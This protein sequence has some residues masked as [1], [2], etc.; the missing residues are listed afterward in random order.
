LILAVPFGPAILV[1]LFDYP[2]QKLKAPW[3]A[4]ACARH[5]TLTR[6]SLSNGLA[7]RLAA[8]FAG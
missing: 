7:G 2:G 3:L 8:L 6:A 4:P 5:L 1:S